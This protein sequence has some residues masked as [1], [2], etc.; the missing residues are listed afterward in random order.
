M[1][2]RKK[3]TTEQAIERMRAAMDRTRQQL[4]SDAAFDISIAPPSW[5]RERWHDKE[6]QRLFIENFIFIRS[7]ED[8]N[9]L[10]RLKLND[11]Q[12]DFHERCTGNDVI[13]KSRQQGFST[14]IL[15]KKFAKAVLF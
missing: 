12:Q 8:E 5:W 15:A 11:V 14:Y 3:S 7:D 10:T 1:A 9:K 6:I 4:Q 2:T 13:L